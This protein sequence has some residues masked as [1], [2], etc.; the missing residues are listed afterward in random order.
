MLPGRLC[1][2][3][4][5]NS[6]PKNL[7]V[8]IMQKSE[9][10]LCAPI[11][12]TSKR[13]VFIDDSGDPGFRIDYGSTRYFVIAA[14]IFS[15]IASLEKMEQVI[16]NYKILRNIPDSTELKFQKTNKKF[17]KE[18]LTRVSDANF[19]IQATVVNK[20]NFS[21]QPIDLGKVNLYNFTV[22][23]VLKDTNPQNAYVYLDGHANKKNQIDAIS[24]FRGQLKTAGIYVKKIKF[25]NSKNSIPMQFAD[26]VAGSIFRSTDKSKT[27]SE[28]YVNLLD[29]HLS[30][31][32][33][34]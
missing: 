33:Y 6:A 9:V 17:V 11:R 15:E 19:E 1:F 12:N 22:S 16:R 26:L 18:L 21:K 3:D 24:Y 20:I 4:L 25:V 10:E 14:V 13:L 30:K 32:E 2:F 29:R 7:A 34:L 31:V 23:K 28:M 8:R 27:D 5:T